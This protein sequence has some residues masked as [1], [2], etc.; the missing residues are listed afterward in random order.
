[1]VQRQEHR[2]I[3]VL[4]LSHKTYKRNVLDREN[5]FSKRKMGFLLECVQF[6]NVD[7]FVYAC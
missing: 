1:M 7:M 2:L 5:P 3:N 6:S 4:R